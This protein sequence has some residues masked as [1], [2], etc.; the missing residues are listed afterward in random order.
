[1]GRN[2]KCGIAGP[3]YNDNIRGPHSVLIEEFNENKTV[4][5][6]EYGSEMYRGTVVRT[7]KKGQTIDATLEVLL[8]LSELL[9]NTQFKIKKIF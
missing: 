6:F 3:I 8:N 1:M 7:Y 9:L 2:V 4:Y 5:S